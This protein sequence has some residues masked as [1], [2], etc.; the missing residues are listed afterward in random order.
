MNMPE[1]NTIPT[2]VQ[3]VRWTMNYGFPAGVC[4]IVGTGMIWAIVR[5][6]NLALAQIKRLLATVREIKQRRS[7]GSAEQE[8]Q[9]TSVMAILA[10]HYGYSDRDIAERVLAA[11]SPKISHRP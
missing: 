9:L 11:A 5:I 8:A 4:L 1:A 10:D 3:I 2:S 7:T 6:V